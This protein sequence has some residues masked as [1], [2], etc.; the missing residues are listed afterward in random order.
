MLTEITQAD[1]EKIPDGT[2]D[3]K[4]EI[5]NIKTDKYLS[6]HKQTLL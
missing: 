6:K 2:L 4:E 1:K 5:K 3:G